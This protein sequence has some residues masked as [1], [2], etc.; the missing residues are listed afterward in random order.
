VVDREGQGPV[1]PACLQA[2]GETVWRIRFTRVPTLPRLPAATTH[3]FTL[4]TALKAAA[5]TMFH[6][7]LHTHEARAPVA[8]LMTDEGPAT[9]PAARPASFPVTARSLPTTIPALL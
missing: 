3:P 1:H 5:T 8:C 2:P 9:D 7:F 4:R 6:V